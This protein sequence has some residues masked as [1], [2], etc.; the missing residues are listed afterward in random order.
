MTLILAIGIATGCVYALVALG[1]SL[2]YRTTAVV[3]FAQG[4]YVMLG[5]LATSW[6]LT[7]W[8]LPYALAVLLGV[9]CAAATGVILWYGVVMPLWRRHSPG[10]VVLLETIIF[11]V[12]A[13][14]AV[15]IALGPTPQT[16]PPWI[17]GFALSFSGDRIDGQYVIVVVAALVAIAGFSAILRYTSLGRAMRACAANRE[18][19]ELLGISPERVGLIAF[20]TTAAL[21]GFGGALIAPAQFTSSDAGLAYGVFGF[22]AA[23]LGGFGSLSGALV[24]GVLL[25]VVNAFVGRYVSSSYQTAI[26]F[27]LL[28]LL[29]TLR[30]EGIIGRGWESE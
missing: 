9:L 5:G 1:Y 23:V 20:A 19:S 16:V 18:V 11:G 12:I 8:K 29:L 26:S 7:A 3:N 2:V 22:V 6:F 13:S 24:G 25:G 10:Y 17:P 27:G 4:S 28:L 14:T 30:P 21:G 15:Q